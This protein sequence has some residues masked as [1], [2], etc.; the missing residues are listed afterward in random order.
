MEEDFIVLRDETGEETE[1]EILDVIEYQGE[2]YV[3]LI[4]VEAAE[5]DPVHIFRIVNED[6]DQ[7]EARYEGLEDTDLIEAVY[8]Q[9]CKRNGL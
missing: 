1:F 3:V 2:E 7:D 5:D 4:P 8:R 6:L 9:F